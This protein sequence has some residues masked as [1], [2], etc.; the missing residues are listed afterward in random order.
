MDLFIFFAIQTDYF[1]LTRY[2][3]WKYT[4]DDDTDGISANS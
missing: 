4:I 2:T 1:I 3:S